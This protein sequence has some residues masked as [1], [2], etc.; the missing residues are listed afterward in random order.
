MTLSGFSG[1]RFPRHLSTG[2]IERKVGVG[3][4]PGVVDPGEGVVSDGA[5]EDDGLR[6]AAPAPGHQ[7][8][9]NHLAVSH[10]DVAEHLHNENIITVMQ[11]MWVFEYILLCKVVWVWH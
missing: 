11:Y 6:G 4:H 7:L 2:P 3:T 5:E 9:A 8:N 1:Y 10:Y